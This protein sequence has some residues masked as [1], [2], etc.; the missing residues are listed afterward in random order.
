MQLLLF[1]LGVAAAAA[2][3]GTPAQLLGNVRVS[4]LGWWAAQEIGDLLGQTDVT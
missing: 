3:L 1:A 2:L 4:E